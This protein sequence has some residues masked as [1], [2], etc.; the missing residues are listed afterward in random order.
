MYLSVELAS[1]TCAKFSKLV[2]FHLGPSGAWEPLAGGS[3][4]PKRGSTTTATTT[5]MTGPAFERIPE[6]A[7]MGLEGGG[8]AVSARIEF[9]LAAAGKGIE[10]LGLRLSRDRPGT[11]LSRSPLAD[12]SIAVANI[13]VGYRAV[14]LRFVPVER[15]A[16]A[17]DAG[18]Q[19]QAGAEGPQDASLASLFCRFQ[20]ELVAWDHKGKN[21]MHGTYIPGR[22][23]LE[24]E[25]EF[26]G[27]DT[28][29][30]DDHEDEEDDDHDY[31]EDDEEDDD[32][33]DEDD[34][35]EDRHVGDTNAY[36]PD[37]RNLT[38]NNSASVTR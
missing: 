29:R 23:L 19:D 24:T 20:V 21:K 10:I 15:F 11:F 38:R 27:Q 1:K 8:R 28:E 2:E 7:S 18:P 33:D 5:A 13:H 4:V 6:D 16:R 25:T 36:D 22:A 35:D 30:E 17:A 34:E 9:P 3:S 26:T 32:E 14:P 31:E 12:Y 37:N